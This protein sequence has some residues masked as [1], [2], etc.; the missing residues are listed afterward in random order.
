MIGPEPRV[1]LLDTSMVAGA[2]L[3]DEPWHAQAVATLRSVAE[4]QIEGVVAP[5]FAFELRSTLVRAAQR[6]RITWEGAAQAIA[7]LDAM[8]LLT[9]TVPLEDADLLE[10]CR[11]YGISWADA[12][13][14]L[15]AIRMAIPLVTADT[16]LVRALQGSD[17]W[18]ESI[19][20]RPKEED[21]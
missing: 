15:V 21:Q 17:V 11:R 5:T 9:A 19:L 3:P 20:D 18:V 6:R 7:T 10:V 13:P 16:R 14:V 8:E 2:V 4:G 1:A 12:N